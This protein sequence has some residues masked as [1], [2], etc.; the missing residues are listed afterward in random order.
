[1]HRSHSPQTLKTRDGVTDTARGTR[2]KKSRATANATAVKHGDGPLSS[3]VALVPLLP[4]R[5]VYCVEHAIQVVLPHRAPFAPHAA[6]RQ[7][8]LQRLWPES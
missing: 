4:R 5:Q 6:L 2:M 7:L 8:R 3:L 1:M